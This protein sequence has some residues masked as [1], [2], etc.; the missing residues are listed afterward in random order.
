MTENKPHIPPVLWLWIPVTWLFVQG[1][2]EIFFSKEMVLKIH[3]EGN[4]HEIAQFIIILA[5][6]LIFARILLYT[7]KN[8]HIG[9]A[10]WVGAAMIC[11]FYVAFEEISWGQSFF[12]W[13]TPDYWR[14]LNGQNETNLHNTSRFLNQIP[15]YGLM[16]S[17]AV[18][19]LFI[20]FIRLM[21]L[22]ILPEKFSTIYPPNILCVTALCLLFIAA[23]NKILKTIW[24]IELFE[25]S[26]E[27]EEIYMF[28]FVFLYALY[29]K[30]TI[31]EKTS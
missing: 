10:L 9:I 25:R 20:P 3:A 15:R 16:A 29:M 30:Q 24:S 1:F 2:I 11:S 7:R 21:K 13:S 31:L 18:G 4:P 22:N 5:S 14:E 28:F 19:G 17:I 27:I 23:G 12:D 26:S 6:A 8:E